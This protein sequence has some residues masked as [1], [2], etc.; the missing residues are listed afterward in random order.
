MMWCFAAFWLGSAQATEPT[1]PAPARGE[2]IAAVAGC[3][4]CHTAEG[5]AP[6]GGG[7]AIPTEQ[8]TFYGTNLTPD[9]THGLGG[10]T[11]GDFERAMRKG[12]SPQGYAYWP[13][14]PYT[15]FTRMSDADL[16]DLWAYLG[17][18]KPVPTAPPPHSTRRGRWQLGLWRPF[19]FVKRG[20]D[21]SASKGEYWVD[22]VAH[23]G[24]CHSPRGKL[25]RI[26]HRRAL[27]GSD[28]QPEPAP[29]ITPGDLPDWT[30]ADWT[31]FLELGMM[32]NG[33]FVGGEMARVVQEGTARL[34]SADRAAMAEFL[35]SGPR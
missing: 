31:T 26:K 8:G 16:Q 34:P 11:Y 27:S 1:A 3:A 30:V 24:E 22:A 32:P 18:L 29:G 13:A 12:K 35:R 20:P 14:F 6:Y 33:D 19:S 10:W 2:V 25:G 17:T 4:A 9:P 7:Y 23:C 21:P 5:G 28:A 15:S